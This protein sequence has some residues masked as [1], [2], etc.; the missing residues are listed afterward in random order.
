[1]GISC[2]NWARCE[3]NTG[4]WGVSCTTLF[5]SLLGASWFPSCYY[6]E[7]KQSA[8]LCSD[9]SLRTFMI[10]STSIFSAAFIAAT[11]LACYKQCKP[12]SPDQVRLLGESQN[13][14]QGIDC[15]ARAI[16][17]KVKTCTPFLLGGLLF[18]GAIVWPINRI[19][20]LF[21]SFGELNSCSHNTLTATGITSIV[22]TA[23]LCA[24]IGSAIYLHLRD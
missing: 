11:T 14:P 9:Q 24:G 21:P 4:Y 10:I 5:V 8:T 19:A 18:G 13:S 20:C 23:L 15:S 22:S 7:D 17:K 6:F 16:G 1:M 12:L 2:I 3:D